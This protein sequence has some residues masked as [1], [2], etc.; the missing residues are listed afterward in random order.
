MEK[1]QHVNVPALYGD[2][3]CRQCDD[4]GCDCDLDDLGLDGLDFDAPNIYFEHNDSSG[5][6][7]DSVTIYNTDS[8][9]LGNGKTYSLKSYTSESSVPAQDTLFGHKI[10]YECKIDVRARDE[11]VLLF[12][13]ILD[14]NNVRDKRVFVYKDNTSWPNYDNYQD[15]VRD[16]DHTCFFNTRFSKKCR[17]YKQGRFNEFIRV[18]GLENVLKIEMVHPSASDHIRDMYDFILYFCK[19][20]VSVTWGSDNYHA[21]D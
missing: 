20:D 7:T 12:K 21:K 1:K 11:Q 16:S 10:V 17:D 4:Y 5:Y 14:S 2:V 9:D 6:T 13:C 15:Y 19:Q 3:T 8:L 18:N